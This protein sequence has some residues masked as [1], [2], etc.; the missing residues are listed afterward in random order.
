MTLTRRLS[1]ALAAV[2]LIFSTQA[3]VYA[4]SHCAHHAGHT[5]APAEPVPDEHAGHGGHPSPAD[6]GG[7]QGACT[8]LGMCASSAPVSAPAAAP[9]A[10]FHHAFDVVRQ[11]PAT[12]FVLPAL[13]R[14][15]IP[16]STAPP[17]VS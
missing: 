9:A 3:D 11:T 17:H 1:A 5:S 15:L 4:S 7:H 13:A 10:G 6:D 12:P 2:L 14:Y 16:F 8:C